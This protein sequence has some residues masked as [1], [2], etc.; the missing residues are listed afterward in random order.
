MFTSRWIIAATLGLALAG[1]AQAQ[2][3]NTES[4]QSAAE[5]GEQAQELPTPF[6]VIIIESDEAAGARER[7]ES[8]RTQREEDD[9]IAQQGMNEATRAMNEATQSMKWSSWVST[10]LVGLGT[11]LLIWTLWLTRSANKAARSSVDVTRDMMAKQMRAYIAIDFGFWPEGKE[12]FF[13]F[14]G[15]NVRVSMPVKNFGQTP[16]TETSWSAKVVLE[17]G[18]TV[19]SE[20]GTIGSIPPGAVETAFFDCTPNNN[21]LPI[22]IRVK[23][24][25]MSMD[26][27]GG[28]EVSFRSDTEVNGMIMSSAEICGDGHNMS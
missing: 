9:L 20:S 8:E 2:D 19:V 11:V 17:N 14:S 1:L 21:G 10:G 22:T 4:N 27:A 23:V 18:D 15:N 28:Y 25:Y 16:S 7:E 12:N 24:S 3:Q 13:V 5:Q 26:K 6:P